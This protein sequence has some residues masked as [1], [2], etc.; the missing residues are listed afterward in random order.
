MPSGE[1]P[2]MPCT[3]SGGLVLRRDALL[4]PVLV[5]GPFPNSIYRDRLDLGLGGTTRE[6][7]YVALIAVADHR[8]SAKLADLARH[9]DGVSSGVSR[10]MRQAARAAG[11]RRIP[12]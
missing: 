2:G 3:T 7:R 11:N 4:M 8:H 1:P 9:P 10:V 6:A 5:F 12:V